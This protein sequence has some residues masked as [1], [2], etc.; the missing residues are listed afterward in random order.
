MSNVLPKETLQVEWSRF[1]TR[2]VLVGSLILLATAALSGAALLPAHIALQIEEKNAAQ[3]SVNK[4]GVLSDAVQQVRSER[5]DVM[6]AQVLLDS[7]SPIVSATSSP[8]EII[9]AVLALRPSSVR[10]DRII[11]VSGEKGTIT[12][13]GTSQGRESINQYREALS[14]SSR[15]EGVSV[16]VGALVGAEGGKFTITLSGKL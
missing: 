2:L 16:P 11:F 5:N 15:F 6:R 3:Q 13:D 7:V 12:I 1:R 8:T 4:S 9:S 14:G 10:I